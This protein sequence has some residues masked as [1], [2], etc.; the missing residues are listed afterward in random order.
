MLLDLDVGSAMSGL[1]FLKLADNNVYVI[2]IYKEHN[3]NYLI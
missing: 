2:N 3:I 1:R